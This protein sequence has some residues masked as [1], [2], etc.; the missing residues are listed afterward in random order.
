MEIQRREIKQIRNESSPF[1]KFL[2]TILFLSLSVYFLGQMV[3]SIDLTRQKLE[4]FEKAKEEVDDL[5]LKN[6]QLIMT[7]ERV[8]TEEYTEEEARNRLNY[9]KDGEILF[10]IPDELMNSEELNN[11]IKRSSY[12]YIDESTLNQ[13]NIELWLT[14]FKEGV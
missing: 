2:T 1:V 12:G 11:Y 3:R 8:I 10:I 4:I 13:D 9:A 6:I 5:R 7:A 14:F